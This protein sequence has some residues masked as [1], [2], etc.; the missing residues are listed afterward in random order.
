MRILLCSN[1][2]ASNLALVQGL[3]G[4]F[5]DEVVLSH[6][7]PTPDLVSELRPHWLVSDRNGHII[8]QETLILMEGRAVNTH[9]SL[10]P[11]H[12]GWQ[13][14]FFSVWNGDPVGVSIHFIDR[15]LDTGNILFQTELAVSPADT[16]KSLYERSRL[17][18][19]E[20][21]VSLLPQ[22]R[23]DSLDGRA[24]DELLGSFH[25]KNDF[26]ELFQLLPRKWDSEVQEVWARREGDA[27]SRLSMEL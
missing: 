5:G 22:M 8:S 19:L 12:R 15:G 18:G 27:F 1:E 26:E 13:P 9:A 17:I 11:N 10:L 3:L 2:S 25:S 21:L 23:A 14:I 6:E 4:V 7:V 24:Q 20:G 16:L